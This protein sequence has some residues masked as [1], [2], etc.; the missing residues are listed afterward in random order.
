MEIARHVDALRREGERLA[1]VAETTDLDTPI[2][3]T[4]EWRMRDLVRHMGDV[5]RW[6]R[7][8][9]G[10]RRM[11]PVGP[12][13]L[14]EIAGPLP[15]D[16]GLVAWFREGHAALVH[17]LEAADDD[18][19]CWSFLPAPSPLAFWARRQAHE[20]GMHR[21]DA[22]SPGGPQALTPFSSDLAVDGIDEL[23]LGFFAGEGEDSGGE[24][25]PTLRVQAVDAAAGWFVHLMGRSERADGDVSE[26]DC[27]VRG[28]ASGLFLLL[29]N[30]L[31]PDRLEVK[32]DPAVLDLWRKN[33]QI[34]W[35]RPR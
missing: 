25:F 24:R 14:P 4:P 8:H 34:H 5:H 11:Q 23:L 27:A 3:T 19:Q 32:G 9:V 26:A 20:T 10:G 21:A 7:A 6:A 12:D 18:L 2:P 13:E 35:S 17:E 28:P 31:A 33:A 30:R 22:E 16:A 15:D 1:T 29:W